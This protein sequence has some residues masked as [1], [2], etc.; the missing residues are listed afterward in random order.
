[1]DKLTKVILGITVT[2][3]V[4]GVVTIMSL[5]MK[6]RDEEVK[7]DNLIRQNNEQNQA[8]QDDRV[9]A[10]EKQ[11]KDAL[12]QQQAENDKRIAELRE[13][14]KAASDVAAK[15]LA[16][17]KAERAQLSETI[18][19][20]IR[21]KEESEELTPLQK[22]IREAPAIAKVIDVNEGLGFIV[23]NAGS[24]KGIE[25]GSRFNIRRDKFIVAEVEI[26]KVENADSSIGNI[27]PAKKPP[28]ISIRKGDE[29]IGYPIF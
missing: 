23:I 17:V 4:I 11:V 24:S 16:A 20:T 29:V 1:M 21:E 9:G 5:L 7:N 25:E 8:R 2:V 15:D 27:D 6:L 28:G 12:A 19:N 14:M 18:A 3:T 10:V 22:K 26:Y 13:E